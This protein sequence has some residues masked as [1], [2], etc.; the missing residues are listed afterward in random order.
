[1]SLLQI[2]GSATLNKELADLL[3][4]VLTGGVGYV[5]KALADYFKKK[6]FANELQNHKD[7]VKLVVTGVEQAY[8]QLHGNEKL[9]MA[10]IELIK[11]ANARGI[12]LDE[13]ELDILI[14][15]CVKEMKDTVSKEI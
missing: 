10:K 2:L 6:G 7:L 9:N 8:S 15:A 13:K 14:E 4:V 12:K 11:L 5:T 3:M 1:M